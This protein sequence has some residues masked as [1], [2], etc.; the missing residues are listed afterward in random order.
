[1][2]TYIQLRGIFKHCDSFSGAALGLRFFAAV[3][4]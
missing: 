3:S 1:M 2:R 4:L